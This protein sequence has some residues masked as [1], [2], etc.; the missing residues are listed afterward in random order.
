MNINSVGGFNNACHMTSSNTGHVSSPKNVPAE[1]SESVDIGKGEP[2]KPNLGVRILR[3]AAGVIGAG[4]GAVIGAGTGAIKGAGE[5]K[6]DLKPIVHKVLRVAGAVAGMG[7]GIALAVAGGPV[8]LAAGVV[9]GP[10]VGALAGGAAGGA[11]EGLG[12]ATLG[13]GAG[14][15]EGIHKGFDIGRTIVDKIAAHPQPAPGNDVPKE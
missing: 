13:A 1:P 8:S 12:S 10:L 7:V 14:A 6:V 15:R 3:T 4:T 11:I 9:A 2:E 5:D